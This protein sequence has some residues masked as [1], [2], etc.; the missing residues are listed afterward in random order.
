VFRVTWKGIL[1]HKLR[2]ALTALAVTLGVAFVAG[3]FI[4]TDTVNAAFVDLFGRTDRSVDTVVRAKATF[5][6]NQTLGGGRDPIP[7]VLVNQVRAVPGAKAVA[8]GVLGYAQL[9]GKD[10]K[11]ISPAG[12]APTLGVAVSQAPELR[13]ISA[14]EG[15]LPVSHDEV[16]ID[17]KT[18]TANN[19]HFGD[20][21]KILFV[22]PPQEFR[23]VGTVLFGDAE[24]LANAT[25]AAFDLS[26]AQQVMNRVGLVDE[27]RVAAEPGVSQQTL[28]D[29]VDTALG[30]KYEVLTGKQYTDSN[31]KTITDNL[32]FFTTALLVFA[33]IS[34]FVGA[35]IIFNTFSILLAQR[36]RE[37]ALLRAL[38]ATA[39]QVTR[40]VLLEAFTVGLVASVLG[41]GLGVLIALG[42]EGL[43]SASGATLPTTSLQ[44]QTRT[45]IWSFAVGI[46]VTLAAAIAP[47]RRTRH[48][49]PVAAMRDGIVSAASHVTLRRVISGLITLAIA[50][51]ALFAGL[52]ADISNRLPLV[53]IG[54]LLTFIAAGIL[55]PLVSRPSARI[56]GWPIARWLGFSGRLG[57]ENA[58]RNPLRTSRTAAAL[59][60]GIGLVSFFTIIA[61]SFKASVTDTI[62]HAIGADYIINNFSSQQGFSIDVAARLQKVPEIGQVGEFR[63]GAWKDAGDSTQQL[64]AS[65]PAAFDNGLFKLNMT[66]GAYA[67]LRDGSVFV[68]KQAADANGY[69]FGDR[70]PMIFAKTGRQEMTISGLFDKSNNTFAGDYFIT[71]GTYAQNY[72][73]QLDSVV[74][75]NLKQGVSLDAG[76]QAIKTALADY[77]QL[78]IDSQASLKKFNQ[79]QIDQLLN[80]IYVLLALA[81]LIA[82]FGI[83]N[84]LALSVFERIRE[85]GLLRA[86]GMTRPQVRRMVTYE[87]IVVAVIGAYLGVVIGSFFGWATVK[88]L[89]DAGVITFSYPVGTVIVF[90]VLAAIAGVIAGLLPAR[91]AARTDILRAVT[92]E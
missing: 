65:D 87:A 20:R 50:L 82:L 13:T 70:L 3:T 64:Q 66:R 58:M 26:T 22:G 4:L 16:A 5:T 88:A 62:D 55:A 46:L 86:V 57:R 29:R 11:A 18:A 67:D 36:T 54:A 61:S 49:P 35:F 53:G 59:M 31:T 84:T 78:R 24:G 9:V 25:L 42:L 85:L 8:G 60:I 7:D 43:F 33:A 6:D 81:I 37:L 44:F 23:V 32:G 30:G 27:I 80:V 15:A 51:A 40:S 56:I 92:S 45:V 52:F 41:L 75:V 63:F 68:S 47:A 39:G 38:G 14:K 76:S 77:P 17:V 2:L 10:G 83:V 89:H 34:L 71:L 1:G 72:T 79:E 28:R 21:V 90:V 48:V 19:L 12:G 73:D 69:H 74:A 91:R